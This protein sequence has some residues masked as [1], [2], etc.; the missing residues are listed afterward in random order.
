M[1]RGSGLTFAPPD[2]ISNAV[3]A[4]PS[5]VGEE[6][7]SGGGTGGLTVDRLDGGVTPASVTG[8]RQSPRATRTPTT[9]TT[10]P[11]AVRISIQLRSRRGPGTG[12]SSLD[13]ATLHDGRLLVVSIPAS[14]R[15]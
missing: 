7:G 9:A 15:P 1:A 2:L 11:A 13:T 5:V 14:H 3:S 10:T 6:V 4:V 8:R 12:G